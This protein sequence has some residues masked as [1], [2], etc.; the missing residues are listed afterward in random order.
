MN[1]QRNKPK[2]AQ[3]NSPYSDLDQETNRLNIKLLLENI[4]K[5]LHFVEILAILD[6]S[7]VCFNLSGNRFNKT[8]IDEKELDRRISITDREVGRR[9]RLIQTYI[10]VFGLLVAYGQESPLQK[11]SMGGFLIFLIFS[12]AYYSAITTRFL[13]V[14][15]CSGFGVS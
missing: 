15:D 13:R 7:G 14:F 5:K 2:Y 3:A 11:F 6:F 1:R 8:E 9:E 4:E 10:V 12:M